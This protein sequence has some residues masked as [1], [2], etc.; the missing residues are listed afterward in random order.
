MGLLGVD[1]CC[2][3]PVAL[4]QGSVHDLAFSGQHLPN[5]TRRDSAPQAPATYR[6]RPLLRPAPTVGSQQPA[7]ERRCA[8]MAGTDYTPSASDDPVLRK[9]PKTPLEPDEITEV[10]GYP[11]D[12]Y[13]RWV[14]RTSIS[15]FCM[16]NNP[17]RRLFAA[18]CGKLN[19]AQCLEVGTIITLAVNRRIGVSWRVC[20]L[21]AGWGMTDD[22]DRLDRL[23]RWERAFDGPAITCVAL[24][25][26]TL[27]SSPLLVVPA[28]A[29]RF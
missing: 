29:S 10:F 26:N 14:T 20:S 5:S 19:T 7:P 21:P 25:L 9:P 16:R 8:R 4:S 11:R 6:R 23:P 15:G 12:H 28:V 27:T 13:T 22:V 18:T 3:T 2:R 17:S 1:V 24:R